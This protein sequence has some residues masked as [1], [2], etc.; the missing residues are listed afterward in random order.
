[1]DASSRLIGDIGGTN[2]RFALAG[3]D[4]VGYTSERSLRCADFATVEDCIE[5]YLVDI[6]AGSPHVI[7]LAAAGPV[8]DGAVRFLNNNWHLQRSSLERRFAPGW[9]RILNDFEAL[10]WA[11]PHLADDDCMAVGDTTRPDLRGESFSVGVVGPGTGFGA[12]GLVAREGVRTA[13]VTE[14][15]HVGF[16]PESSLQTEVWQRLSRKHGRVSDERLVSGPGLVDTFT[17]LCAIRGVAAPTLDAAEIFRRC[18]AETDAIA[19]EAV[20]LLF[21]MF[22]QVAGNFALSV[23]TW[24]GLYLAGGIVHK[25]GDLLARSRF[26]EAFEAK[27]R[28]RALMRSIPTVIVRHPQ[29]GL[30]GASA[31]ASRLQL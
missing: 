25:Q 29:P 26:R 8:V 23:G 15:G 6:G 31:V 10:A 24:D 21:E 22:G 2:A 16:G 4:G 9:I 18:R 11:L 1:M 13:L 27:G 17:A 5:E 19:V 14:A 28:H 30:L 20:G 3:T 7:C 12:A